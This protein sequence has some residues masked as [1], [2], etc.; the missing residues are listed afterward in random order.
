MA[1]G[2]V[3]EVSPLIVDQ[4]NSVGDT[5]WVVVLYDDD[6]HSV[7]EVVR[8]LQKATN[9]S[10]ERA[11]AVVEEV[12]RAGKSVAYTSSLSDC[13]AVA[14]ILQAIDLTVELDRSI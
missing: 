13:E 14:G 5:P 3:T 2:T 6:W 7:D 1:T 12:Q 9:Y 11:L 8:Q 4:I 10:L